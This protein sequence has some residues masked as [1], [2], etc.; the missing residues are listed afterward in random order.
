M[1]SIEEV[2]LIP[3]FKYYVNILFCIFIHSVSELLVRTG[4]Y[5][6][7]KSQEKQFLHK[8]QCRNPL[9]QSKIQGISHEAED[10]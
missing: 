1:S 7:I 5:G 10:G 6:D 8:S 3:N 9:F 2:N 4:R